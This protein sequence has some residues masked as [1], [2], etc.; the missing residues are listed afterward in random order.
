[1]SIANNMPQE[2]NNYKIIGTGN[3]IYGKQRLE[4][5]VELRDN[6]LPHIK[7]PW[8]IENGTLL[9]A[10]RNNKFIK[11]DDD[12]DYALLIDNDLPPKETITT[13][14]EYIKK[15]LN[16]KY[17]CRLI[18]TYSDKIEIYD[19]KYGKYLLAEKYG[20]ADYHYVSIDLQFYKKINESNYQSMYY[21]SSFNSMVDTK[22]ILPLQKIELENY[23]FPAPFDTKTFLINHYG[24][25]DENAKYN[26]KTGKYH[27]IR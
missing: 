22:V 6:I 18:S 8:F 11:L 15:N 3:D 25:L 23:L 9:G 14:Y 27:L 21:I 17:E 26:N 19:P 2:Y 20:G 16:K 24:S 7:H 12:F 1:M 4:L 5:A 10:W 13:I